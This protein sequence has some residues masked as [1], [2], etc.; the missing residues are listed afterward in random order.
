MRLLFLACLSPKTGNCTTAERLRCH[1]EAA[2]HTCILRNCDDIKDHSDVANLMKKEPFEAALAIHLFKGGRF[3]LDI[4]VPFGIVFGGTDV[5][6]DVKDERKRTVMEHVLKKARFSVAFT[7][8]MKEKAESFLLPESSK[9]RVQPQGI[10]TRCASDFSWSEFLSSSGVEAECVEDMCVFLL[11]CGLRRVKDPLYLLKAFSEWHAS[12]P[13][14]V[15]IIIGPKMDPVFSEEVEESVSR[16]AGVYHTAEREQDELHAAMTH[17]F[18]LV[19]SSISEGMSAAI[20]EA[21]DLGLPVLAR[22]IPG[23]AAIVQHEVTG[24]LYSSPQEF[25]LMAKRLLD[26]RPLRERLAENGKHYVGEHHSFVQERNTYQE[27][28]EKLHS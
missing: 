28:V 25:I 11:V 15:F 8:Q 20:L 6:E 18:A 10:K 17:S 21:M 1:I 19:N 23:N 27:L 16:W 24:L 12:H 22:D 5:N 2:G 7:P 26:D 3:L 14:V 4:H 13:Q 9:I